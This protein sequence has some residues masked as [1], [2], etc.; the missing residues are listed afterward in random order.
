MWLQV[1][2][3][4]VGHNDLPEGICLAI[5]R[6]NITTD[7]VNASRMGR[8]GVQV[9]GLSNMVMRSFVGH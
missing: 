6:R 5:H 4:I 1:I 8:T 2:G 7:V 3:S 9:D